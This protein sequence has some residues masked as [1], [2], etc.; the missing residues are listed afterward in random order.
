M[1]TTLEVGSRVA[2]QMPVGEYQIPATR[3]TAMIRLAEAH[4]EPNIRDCAEQ[5]YARYVPAIGRKPAP[6]VADFAAQIAAGAVYVA[7]DEHCTFQGFVV[8]HARE[9]H[10]LLES[11]AVLP[12]ATGRGVGKSLIAFCESA[13]RERGMQTVQLY[14]N[15]M[16]AD[17]LLIYPKLGYVN[18]GQRTEDGF[19]R[20]YFEKLLTLPDS[21]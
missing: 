1:M 15:V 19:K 2:T 4:D 3:E 18:V 5:A 16:M 20:V 7:T 6:M 8:F 12:S 21:I 13:G 14:T 11:V 17:N 9:E 10:I